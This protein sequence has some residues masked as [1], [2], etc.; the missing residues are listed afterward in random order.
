M[1]GKVHSD[2]GERWIAEKEFRQQELDLKIREQ[3]RLEKELQFRMAEASRSRW[4]N[5]LVI[6]ILAATLAA[7]GN[8]GEAWLSGHAQRKIQEENNRSQLT[9]ES[10]KAE[11]ARILEVI[12]TNNPDT[13]ATNLKFLLDA[14]LIT[15]SDTAD[16]IR[17]FL[18]TRSAGEGPALPSPVPNFG[19][20]GPPAPSMVSNV[21]AELWQ[22]YK[23][24]NPGFVR[25]VAAKF[26]L[27]LKGNSNDIL[28]YLRKSDWQVLTDG[29]SAARAAAAGRLVIAGLEGSRQKGGSPAD[30]GHVAIV[31]AG[32]LD[33]GKYPTIY[34]AA[35]GLPSG[36]GNVDWVWN[37]DDR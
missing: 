21:C 37:S 28:A 13:A 1:S 25:A 2:D 7:G 4:S 30:H 29:P 22:N 26:G 14:H 5:P 23:D 18:M 36:T 3:D 33:K 35:Y 12:K 10:F 27:T 19:G 6:A 17:K 16:Y 9:L 8:A 34:V 15:R 11:S 32:P 20:A 31:V 24:D